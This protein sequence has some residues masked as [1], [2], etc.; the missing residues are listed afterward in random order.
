MNQKI[1]AIVAILVAM[2]VFT[3]TNAVFKTS[4]FSYAPT[5]IV[6]FRN[7][8]ALI[9]Y[10]I[11]VLAQGEL[12][13]LSID[14]YGTHFFRGAIGV[15]SLSCLFKSLMMMPLADAMTLSYMASIFMVLLSAPLLKE[16]IHLL[17]WIAVIMGFLGVV[18]IAQPQGDVFN[19]GVIFGLISAFCEAFIMVHGRLISHKNSN[20]AIVIYYA[21]FATLISGMTLPFVW[22]TP[23]SY[24]FMV[25][26][27][28][29]IGGGI[30]QYLVTVAYRHAP[31]ETL[32]PM[33]Y[34]SI[35]WSFFY[36]VILFGE[37]PSKML[38]AGVGLI[39]AAG[40][41]VIFQGNFSRGQVSKIK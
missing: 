18:I 14:N 10:G 19:M 20:S 32:S 28:L 25:L 5:Q 35:I 36:G 4:E 17:G 21:I 23:S 24:D 33:I 31:M 34:T 11:M 37:I 38:Y 27:T 3:T 2:F 41:V 7:L 39:I 12:K 6:F 1:G 29:G 30:G 13:T 15:I 8:F 16:R 26:A 22:V 9:P 40:I